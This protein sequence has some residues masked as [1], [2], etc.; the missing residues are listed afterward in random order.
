LLGANDKFKADIERLKRKYNPPTDENQTIDGKEELEFLQTPKSREITK[1]YLE[2]MEKYDLTGL[3]D[4]MMIY[5]VESGHLA[6]IIQ[7]EKIE[8]DSGEITNHLLLSSGIKIVDRKKDYATIN[9]YPETT[10][11]DIEKC[12]PEIKKSLNKKT[13]RKIESPNLERDL[14]ILSLKNQG[15]KAGEIAKRINANSDFKDQKI[16]YQDVSRI[17]KRLKT[18]ARNNVPN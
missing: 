11:K 8:V 2:L 7:G 17:V 16:T 12:L 4:F 6:K 1:E 5:L 13:G 3:V 15:L 9:I 18:K 14:K 10:I